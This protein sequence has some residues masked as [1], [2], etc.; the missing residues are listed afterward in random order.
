MQRRLVVSR[1]VY[2][3]ACAIVGGLFFAALG[4]MVGFFSL[5]HWIGGAAWLLIVM[6]VLPQYVVI[7]NDLD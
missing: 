2:V 6:Y 7:A 5:L 1:P 4:A 3:L